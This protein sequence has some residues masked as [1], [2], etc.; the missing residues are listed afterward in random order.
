MDTYPT[1]FELFSRFADILASA[2]N[3]SVRDW[4]LSYL[5]NVVE[6]ASNIEATLLC[7]EEEE[8][9]TVHQQLIEASKR[10]HFGEPPSLGD[11]VAAKHSLYALLLHNAHLPQELYN[12]LL[13]TYEFEN[14]YQTDKK[15][16]VVQDVQTCARNCATTDLLLLMSSTLREGLGII[17]SSNQSLKPEQAAIISEFSFKLTATTIVNRSLAR[18]LLEK[19]SSFFYNGH[20]VDYTREQ[21]M[22][23]IASIAINTSEGAE[24]IAHT[25]I[26]VTEVIYDNPGLA[27]VIQQ[28][29]LRWITSEVTKN[30]PRQAHQGSIVPSSSLKERIWC[31]HPWLLGQISS[32][33][34]QFFEVY[35]KILIYHLRQ[36]M[37]YSPTDQ[38]WREMIKPRLYYQEIKNQEGSSRTIEQSSRVK[39]LYDQWIALQLQNPSMKIVTI[40]LLKPEFLSS[41]KSGVIIKRGLVFSNSFI[42][43]SMTTLTGQ[44][45]LEKSSKNKKAVSSSVDIRDTGPSSGFGSRLLKNAEDVFNHN[46]WDNVIWNEE[47]EKQAQEQVKKQF[48]KVLSSENQQRFHIEAAEFWNTFYQKNENKFFKD[49]HWLN[50]E[51]P[52]LH[53]ATLSEAGQKKVF[54]VGCGAGNTLFPLLAINQNLELFL[55]ACDFSST[56][57]EVVKGNPGYKP[58]HSHAFVWDLT[59]PQLPHCIEPGS[60]DIIVLIFVFSAIRPEEWNQAVENIFEVQR[61]AVASIQCFDYGRYD[62]VQLRFKEGQMLGENFYVR[63]DGTRVYF[64]TTDEIESLWGSR[65]EIEQIAVDRRLIV[66]R[67]RKLKM[68]RNWLQEPRMLNVI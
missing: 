25:A 59:S 50:V 55:Y 47:Q 14:H 16:N 12:Y 57:V 51:F 39:G 61:Y 31:S 3:Y 32:L 21:L 53:A 37:N 43:K 28:L 64:F 54:E 8:A 24:V 13:N 33:D 30:P 42:L 29:L 19:I 20:I 4:S 49:R 40:K 34:S 18:S 10:T 45:E 62:M 38:S 65:F 68:Y 17:E 48:T 1:L 63:G 5:K 60:I 41:H 22:K 52:E 67:H 2:K 56:A 23:E 6:S 7:V 27:A 26:L 46:A 66:N 9:N 36:E 58:N 15:A 11:F 44:V 35:T